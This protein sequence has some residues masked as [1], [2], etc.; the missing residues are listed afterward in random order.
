MET[1]VHATAPVQQRELR[2]NQPRPPNSPDKRVAMSPDS[3]HAASAAKDTI[4][5]SMSRYRGNRPAKTPASVPVPSLDLPAALKQSPPRDSSR[6]SAMQNGATEE[7]HSRNRAITP[8]KESTHAA[9]SPDKPSESRTPKTESRSTH[10]IK[11]GSVPSRGEP[12]P[13]TRGSLIESEDHAIVNDVSQSRTRRRES[14]SIGDGDRHKYGNN[15][16]RQNE[17]IQVR[18]DYELQK[19][20]LASISP[21]SAVAR[22]IPPK[23]SFTERM[24]DHISKYQS[25]TKSDSK[26]DL[27]KMISTPIAIG[28]GGEVAVPQF[29]APISAVNAGERRVIVKSREFIISLPVLPSTTPADIIRSLAKQN[30]GAVDVN[31][32]V[33]VESFKQVGLERP[34]RMYE[35]IRD[36]LNSWDTDTQ[37]TLVIEPSPTG[38]ND[39]DLDVRKV[40]KAQP[41]ETSVYLYYSQKPGR[42]DKR[43]VT[44]RSD[45]QVLVKK[46]GSESTNICHLSDFDIYV[47]TPRQMA[48]KI[49]PPKKVCFAVKSQQKSSMF[50]STA[51]FIHFF[52]TGDKK[53]ATSWYKAVQEWR[54][55]YLVNVM[56]EGQ[57]PATGKDCKGSELDSDKLA[58]PGHRPINTLESAVCAADAITPHSLSPHMQSN[59]Q[60]S[61]AG[62]G[63]RPSTAKGPAESNGV[64]SKQMQSDRQPSRTGSGQRPSTAQGSA[65]SNGILSSIKPTRER[66]APPVSFPKY[67]MEDVTIGTSADTAKG[68]SPEDS[69]ENSESLPFSSTGLLGRTYSQRQ[70][71]QNGRNLGSR[72]GHSPTTHTATINEDAGGLRR[73]TSMRQKPKPLI[74]LTPVYQEPPQH[75]RKG[76]GIVPHQIPA[77]GLVNIATSPEVAIPIPPTKT[78]RR[79]AGGGGDGTLA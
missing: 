34:L 61:R 79:A 9:S 29:D 39:D 2:H 49:K 7:N 32:S 73:T 4:A 5:R 70:K 21:A 41:G 72:H 55:W 65:E 68:N 45:G 35:H 26:A 13:T 23:K 48:K 77:G 25:T 22:Q 78:W 40:S 56:G 44:L 54:S 30:P 52:S 6:R 17:R 46:S 36:V 53:L 11:R 57:S 69:A 37:N 75:T 62:T 38:G 1:K 51:N 66:A 24:V 76:K 71:A 47:P 8:K 10:S 15:V 16:S 50:L 28:S 63:Q 64:L 74:D 43:W 67:L 59:R 3:N 19:M 14:L 18:P 31:A 33:L 27:K 42:W 58:L 12:R 60:P 20:S